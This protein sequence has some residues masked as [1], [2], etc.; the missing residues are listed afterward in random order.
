MSL[1]QTTGKAKPNINDIQRTALSYILG[2]ETVS[3]LSSFMLLLCL[4]TLQ[5]KTSSRILKLNSMSPQPRTRRQTHP[6]NGHLDFLGIERPSR[7]SSLY[8]I[9]PIPT[10]S[11]NAFGLHSTSK[12]R[13]PYHRP[14][15]PP[16][17]CSGPGNVGTRG[18]SRLPSLA[19]TA[20]Y[21]P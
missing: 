15:H 3:G 14:I 10:S 1:R 18:N 12:T 7:L 6:R 5:G 8:S 13:R 17:Q 21:T 19:P 2:I 16:S 9:N 20:T 4:H 11:A